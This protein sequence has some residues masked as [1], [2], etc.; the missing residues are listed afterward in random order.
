M[1]WGDSFVSG[2]Q[3]GSDA[4]DRKK[5]R[6]LEEA[7]Q[8][9]KR[10]LTQK[11]LDADVA[12]MHAT[13]GHDSTQRALDRELQAGLV[14]KRLTHQSA[15]GD[16]ERTW[17]TGERTGAEAFQG[18]Q[19]ELDRGVRALLEGRRLEQQ[20]ELDDAAR[21]FQQRKLD[22]ETNPDNPRNVLD[23][24][25]ANYFRRGGAPDLPALPNAQS[26]L[27][28]GSQGGDTVPVT[29]TTQEEYDRLPSGARFNWGGRIG[30]KP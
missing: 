30:R 9:L 14:D 12:K 26:A 22:W 15:E 4:R 8:S 16:K 18:S 25:H 13:F 29:I 24:E 23:R 2:F 27:E 3:A 19:A 28:N 21:T 7:E 1:P 17:R 10:E 5:R 6:K 11:Q 20:R